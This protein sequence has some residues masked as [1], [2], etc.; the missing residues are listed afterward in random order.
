MTR[1]QTLSHIN[2]HNLG[3]THTAAC[4]RFWADRPLTDRTLFNLTSDHTTMS[5][6][7]TMYSPSMEETMDLQM[8]RLCQCCSH[9][10]LKASCLQYKTAKVAGIEVSPHI[11]CMRYSHTHTLTLSCTYAVHGRRAHV[12][13]QAHKLEQLSLRV[14]LHCEDRRNFIFWYDQQVRPGASLN[15]LLI[16]APRCP[17]H[18]SCCPWEVFARNQRCE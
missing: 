9:A 14:C 1:T 8:M 18:A 17:I 10:Q 13:I 3:H 15:H 16:L 2:I 7:G 5:G 12:W 11:V 6:E 4:F